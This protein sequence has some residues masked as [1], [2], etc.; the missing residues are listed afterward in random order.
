[1]RLKSDRIALTTEGAAIAGDG[2]RLD[3]RLH[4]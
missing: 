1:L 2:I 3:L 4:G